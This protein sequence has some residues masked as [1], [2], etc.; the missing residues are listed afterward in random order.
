MSDPVPDP[1]PAA[2]KRL[3]PGC[4]LLLV[5]GIWLVALG[6]WMGWRLVGQVREMR[7]FTDKTA[8]AM[9]PLQ[10]D[11]AAL[12]E[13]RGRLSAFADAVKAKTASALTLTDADLNHLLASQ[14]PVNRLQDIMRVE[15]ITD[16]IRLRVALAINGIP[17]TGERLYL[18]GFI[19]ARP[20][21]R[22][23][24]GLVL[25][26]RA[27]DVPGREVSDGFRSRYLEAN[28]VDGLV[29]DEVRKNAEW[30]AVL[31]NVTAVRA[32]PGKVIVEYVPPV[33]KAK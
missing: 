8:Q 21:V 33:E 31:D 15:E 23:D 17:F 19:N 32:E 4:L 3:T 2:S 9:V 29:F 22:S 25:L 30:K 11:A 12:T 6:G 14:E 24:S 7:G 13:L 20:E 26:T 18:N 10:P 27:L 5:M 1:A 16:V 28:H